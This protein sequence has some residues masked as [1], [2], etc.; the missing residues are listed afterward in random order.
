M[1]EPVK[2]LTGEELAEVRRES[3]EPRMIWTSEIIHRLLATI[4]VK[5]AHPDRPGH[6]TEPERCEPPA[7]EWRRAL[8]CL[9]IAVDESVARDVERK[10]MDAI[11]ARDAE[12]AKLRAGSPCEHHYCLAN[13]RRCCKCDQ[14]REE[15]PAEPQEATPTYPCA[16]CGAPRTKEEG[17][18]TFTVC[19]ACWE[20]ASHPPA[21]PKPYTPEAAFATADLFDRACLNLIG[22]DD[23]HRLAATLRAYASQR[24]EL[25][26]VKK[27]N[28]SLRASVVSQYELVRRASQMAVEEH[29]A[30]LCPEDVGCAE[31]VASHAHLAEHERVETTK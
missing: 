20:R 10:V 19:D 11:S 26:R 12:L 13:T 29:E 17:G 2:P 1:S 15:P 28:S 22:R 31:L 3:Q 24:E 23:Q 5:S 18:T 8:K 9:Y 21:E 14:L 6:P 25:E 27:E 7:E 16:E 4:D 30:A